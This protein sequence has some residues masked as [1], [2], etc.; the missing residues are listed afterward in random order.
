MSDPLMPHRTALHALFAALAIGRQT[1]M[2]NLPPVP[3]QSERIPPISPMARLRFLAAVAA[4]LSLSAQAAERPKL[5]AE[6]WSADINV[7]DP[8]ACSV[9]DQGRVFVS[10]TTRRKVGDLDIREW[11]QWIPDD[12]SFQSVADKRAFYHKMLAPGQAAPKGPL[13]DANGDGSIDWKDLTVPTERIYRLLDSNDD[14]KADQITSFAEGF[15]TEVTG[16]AA[17]VLA[18]GGSVYSTIAPDVWRLI[19]KDGDGKADSRE[20][21]AH[22]F[23]LHI[24]YAGHDM[25]G[26]RVG[27]DGRIYWSI[28]DKGTNVT[29]REGRNFAYPNEGA[30]L[31][32]EPDGS[33]FEVFAHGLRNVQETDFNELGD[34]FGVDNDADKPGEK[35]RLVFIADQSD[36]GWRCGFQYMKGAWCPWTSEGRWQPAHP[37]QPLFITPPM[38]ASHDGPAGFVYNPGTALNPA[39]RGWFFLNQF[40]SGK[41]NALRLEPAGAAWKLAEEV[42]ISERHHGHRH[43][44]GPGRKALLRRLGGR[45]SARSKRRC[46]DPRCRSHRTRSPSRRSAPAPTRRFRLARPRCPARLARPCR[47][48]PPQRRPIRA[49]PPRCLGR[50]S[51][52]SRAM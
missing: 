48:P 41:M 38:A 29:S 8:V 7:P 22:G 39:W 44:L 23:G 42:Q 18:F 49:R 33:R 6:K 5:T 13:K 32:S 46:L 30:V 31:R 4:A 15:N 14:G 25:H 26:L 21:I 35:E 50:I 17:G 36:S 20:S 3:R 24:A 45:L 27:P 47:C 52:L 1:K 2:C 11:T 19:D 51:S 37:F 34:L 28:G 43:E 10:A 16:I 40:P 12:Q 9:D